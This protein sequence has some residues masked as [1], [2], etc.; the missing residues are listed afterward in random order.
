MTWIKEMERA[1]DNR[2]LSF[3]EKILTPK[4]LEHSLGVVQVMGELADIY[5][6]DRE[7]SLAAGLLHDAAKDLTPIQQAEILLDARIE[8]RH[9]CE[10]DYTHYL[11]GPVGAYLIQQE[12]GITDSFI[13]DAVTTHTYC[14]DGANFNAPICWCLRFADILE[15]TRNWNNVRWLR[16]GVLRLRETVYA[17]RLMEGAFLQT[18]WLIK[19]FGETG[20]PVHPNML[21]AYQELSAALNVNDSFLEQES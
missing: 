8:I 13:L 7:T 16:N 9:E 17:G 6:I 12:L 10:L 2:Y 20:V 14:G 1:I 11:H 21:R 18:G 19:W 15:P 5:E 4:R 3:I